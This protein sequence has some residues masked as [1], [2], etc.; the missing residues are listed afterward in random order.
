MFGTALPKHGHENLPPPAPFLL[1]P[2]R[3]YNNSLQNWYSEE[4]RLGNVGPEL[5]KL[6]RAQPGSGGRAQGRFWEELGFKWHIFLEFNFIRGRCPGFLF[7]PSW[8][9][10]ALCCVTGELQLGQWKRILWGKATA[11]LGFRVSN[12][13]LST[14]APSSPTSRRPAGSS[15]L[16]PQHLGSPSC[17]DHKHRIHPWPILSF[18]PYIQFTSKSSTTPSRHVMN[19][20]T[21]HH[22]HLGPPD[23]Q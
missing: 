4:P 20:A 12:E 15:H 17:L 11:Y 1:P 7:L 8:G 14:A 19:P 18:T 3:I 16:S 22:L 9:T 21:S 6:V 23:P 10:R 5:L 13:A 2:D